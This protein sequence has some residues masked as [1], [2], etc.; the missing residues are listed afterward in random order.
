MAV[1]IDAAT[2]AAATGI[3]ATDAERLLATASALVTKY[4]ADAPDAID[5]EAVIRVAGYLQSQ[6]KAALR[7]ESVGPI[8][9]QYAPSRQSAL[10]HSGAMSLLSPFKVRRGGLVGTGPDL[11]RSPGVRLLQFLVLSLLLHSRLGA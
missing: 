3:D 5:N 9:T 11:L 7:A 1:T 4:G 10:R 8:E 2:L 6:P